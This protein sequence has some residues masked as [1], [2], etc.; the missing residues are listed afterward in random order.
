[1]KLHELLNETMLADDIE[2]MFQTI[3]RIVPDRNKQRKILKIIQGIPADNRYDDDDV[4]EMYLQ[5]EQIVTREEAE[6]ILD[7]INSLSG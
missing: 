6:Q 4:E 1:M 3:T 5:I 2:E 7:V